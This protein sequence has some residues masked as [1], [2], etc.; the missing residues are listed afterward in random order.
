MVS[1]TIYGSTDTAKPGK[2][3]T[4]LKIAKS[5]AKKTGNKIDITIYVQPASS[6]KLYV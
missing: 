3:Y 2:P 6:G 1:D 4:M 5:T